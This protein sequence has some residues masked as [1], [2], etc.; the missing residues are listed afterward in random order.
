VITTLS[1]ASAWGNKEHQ[2]VH[3]WLGPCSMVFRGGLKGTEGGSSHT[4][5]PNAGAGE[6]PA[7]FILELPLAA[8][9][10]G[11]GTVQAIPYEL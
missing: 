5:A 6:L 4:H 10:L 1:K 2:D 11:V 9:L 8:K 3:Q 7:E